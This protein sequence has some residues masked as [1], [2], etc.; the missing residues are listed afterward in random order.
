MKTLFLLIL[1]AYLYYRFKPRF[2][3]IRETNTLLFYYNSK[4]V[5]KLIILFGVKL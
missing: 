1:G 2:D 5:R 3:Y 4:G